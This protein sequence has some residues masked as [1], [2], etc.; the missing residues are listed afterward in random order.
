MRWA[1]C[2]MECGGAQ[3]GKGTGFSSRAMCLC[4]RA[5][6]FA[7]PRGTQESDQRMNIHEYQAKELLAKFGIGIPP[8]M[9]R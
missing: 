5:Q 9:P 2:R 4:A 3:A 7:L 8:A 1:N 6:A